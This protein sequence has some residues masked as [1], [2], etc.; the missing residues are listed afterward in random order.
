MFGC[1]YDVF[2]F[3]FILD[4]IRKWLNNYLKILI[5]KNINYIL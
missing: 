1:I 4:S 3:Y 5:K 2:I